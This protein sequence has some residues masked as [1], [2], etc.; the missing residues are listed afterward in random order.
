MKVD[1]NKLLEDFS[2]GKEEVYYYYLIGMWL[3]TDDY[4][5]KGYSID[6]IVSKGRDMEE[7]IE[8]I[9]K[10]ENKIKR[11][12][13]EEYIPLTIG[14]T[15][16]EATKNASY[17]RDLLWDKEILPNDEIIKNSFD[18]VCRKEKEWNARNK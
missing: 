18:L 8:E 6:L 2:N 11:I 1:L 13:G 12:S 17:F 4:N 15:V 14:K 5:S 9:K 7:A 16:F 3:I 10:Y